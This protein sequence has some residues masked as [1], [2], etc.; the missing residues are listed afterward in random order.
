M[1]PEVETRGSGKECLALRLGRAWCDLGV[2]E[3]LQG[4]GPVALLGR[5]KPQ[6][7]LRPG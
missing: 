4:E 5:K 6:K 1:A 7:G 2:R 3:G